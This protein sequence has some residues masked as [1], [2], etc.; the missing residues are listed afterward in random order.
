MT[1]CSCLTAGAFLFTASTQILHPWER[2]GVLSFSLSRRWKVDCIYLDLN[3]I[4]MKADA[5]TMKLLAV[6][7][8][9][10]DGSVAERAPTDREMCMWTRDLFWSGTIVC[11]ATAE[12]LACD[13]DLIY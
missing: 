3:G 13:G 8:R 4:P 1:S 11:R 6:L 5:D 2:Y 10:G 7:E 9:A 12:R